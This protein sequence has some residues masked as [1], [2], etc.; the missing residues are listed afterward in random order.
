MK[1]ELFFPLDNPRIVTQKFGENFR[2]YYGPG[3]HPGWDIVGTFGQEIRAA[4]NGMVTEN[5]F[6]ETGTGWTLRVRH[7]EYG[8][9][10]TLY[11]HMLDRSPFQVGNQVLCGKVIGKVGL[12][13]LTTGAHLHCGLYQNGVP[14]DPAPY[15]NGMSAEDYVSIS[16]Q[17]KI[18]AE[19]VGTLIKQLWG[20]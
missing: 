14:V 2:D 3:G 10:E 12:T 8:E 11:G 5:K 1:P 15:W 13:G 6:S 18:L 17:L 19:K 20:K 7:G 16:N 9:F 4:H